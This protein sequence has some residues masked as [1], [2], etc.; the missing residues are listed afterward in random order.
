MNELPLSQPTISQQLKEL[1]HVNII[2][3]SVEGHS[4]C[5]C[6]NL[7]PLE[8]IQNYV[9]LTIEGATK[10]KPGKCC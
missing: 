10:C 9:Q 3:G 2:Q 7:E 4:I 8:K 1:K 5:Y 6:L